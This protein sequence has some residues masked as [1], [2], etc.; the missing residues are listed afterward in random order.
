MTG[1]TGEV[2]VGGG[3]FD[4]KEEVEGSRVRSLDLQET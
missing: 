1:F 2:E 3:E 4:E